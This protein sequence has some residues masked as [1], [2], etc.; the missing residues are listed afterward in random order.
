MDENFNALYN[1]DLAFDLR[2]IYAKIVGD[3]LLDISDARKQQN[4]YL[5]FKNLEDL[6]TIV[7]HK[8]KKKEEEIEYEKIVNNII[9][10]SNKYSDVWLA[11]NKDASKVSEFE[12]ALRE[13]EMFLYE[14]MNDAHM[15]GQ[16]ARIPGL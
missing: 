8:F 13:L 4:F 14:K 16:Q 1:Q 15:F 6:H 11:Q 10:L 5:W 2:Q 7:R 3:H 9:D 12:K